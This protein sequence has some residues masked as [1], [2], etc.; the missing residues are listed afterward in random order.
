MHQDVCS[1]GRVF[2]SVGEMRPSSPRQLT[3]AEVQSA[4]RARLWEQA[5]EGRRLVV[6]RRKIDAAVTAANPS[7]GPSAISNKA[8]SEE[9]RSGDD[10]DETDIFER[11]SFVVIGHREITPVLLQALQ[12]QN[13]VAAIETEEMTFPLTLPKRDMS[14]ALAC[15][16]DI[17]A[18]KLG[19]DRMSRSGKAD[20]LYGQKEAIVPFLRGVRR[21]NRAKAI[22][23][24]GS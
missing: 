10:A 20:K 24:K 3:R 18:W 19:I 12:Q 4:N 21:G 22:K 11:P 2:R 16:K 6:R 13:N 8:A 1:S 5:L 9:M 7:A 17:P 14:E 15:I 23:R